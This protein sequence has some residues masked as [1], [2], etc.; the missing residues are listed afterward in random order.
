MKIT[1]TL[2]AFAALG[3]LTLF[4]GTGQLYAQDSG[5]EILPAIMTID[6]AVRIG[7]ARN[8]SIREA[9]ISLDNAGA[10]VN[11]AFGRFLP[12]IGVNGGYSRNLSDGSTIIEGTQQQ[13]ARPADSYSAS[14]SAS[15]VL[16]DGFSNTASYS[17][18][19]KSY[20]AAE[21]NVEQALSQIRWNVRQTFLQALENKQI[22]DVREAELETAREQLE[23][24]RGRVDGGIA[25][26]D[27]L[28]S[29]ESE[30]ASAELALEQALTNYLVSRNTLSTML[31]YDPAY[32]YELSSAGLAEILDSAV[33]A[34]NRKSLGSF[35]DL[36]TRQIGNRADIQS[37][38][39]QAEAADSRIVAANSSYYPTLS[40]SLGWSWSKSGPLSSSNAVLG[41]SASWTLFNGFQTS[42]QVQVAESQKMNAQISIRRLELE[43]RSSLAGALARL[44]GAERSLLA[45]EKAVRAARQSRF[46]ADERLKEGIGSYTDYLLANTRFVN[47]R[48][49]QVRSTFSYRAALYEIEY[50]IGGR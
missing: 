22:V 20:D 28:Y 30:V 7:L 14:A 2:F 34:E 38:R 13:A 17:A 50:L 31:N 44:E 10:N 23:L 42:E 35:E 21:Q 46:A 19:Q 15:L 8:L 47:A 43:A 3:A 16:F 24:V 36:L 33:V 32:E 27:A 9:E 4:T 37:L 18:A 5:E 26:I 40:S 12:R 1:A 48:I 45:A 39:F 29:Q 6:D 25:L 49:Q 41:F 11:S